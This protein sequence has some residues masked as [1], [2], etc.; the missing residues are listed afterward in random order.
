MARR[1][2]ATGATAFMIP[3]PGFGF[4]LAGD[5]DLLSALN[6][7]DVL[8]DEDESLVDASLETR[9]AIKAVEAA[10]CDDSAS[11]DNPDSPITVHDSGDAPDAE[12]GDDEIVE[13]VL[14]AP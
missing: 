6:L 12:P 2:S 5:D 11:D 14:P 9:A 10:G 4:N 13:F 7:D 8:D 1:N 3:F